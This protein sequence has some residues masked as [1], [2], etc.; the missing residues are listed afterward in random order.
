L[1]K[2][3][4]FRADGNTDIGFGHVIRCLALADMLKDHF[5]CI[6]ATRFVNKYIIEEIEK[7]CS[8]YIKL[9]EGHN[10]HFDEFLACVFK[11]DIVVL[12]NYFFT[13]DYQKQIKSIECKLICI[14]DMH[15]KHYVADIVIN[16]GPG[17][18][19]D[20]FSAE[21]YT[22]L[23]LGLDY[24]LLRKPFLNI[25]QR[26]RTGVKKCLVCI[27]G[28]DKHNITSKILNLLEENVNIDTVDVIIGSSFLFKTE[29]ENHIDYSEKE[30]NLYSGLSSNEMLDRM[31]SAD[32]G[33]FPASSISLEAISVGLPFMV[34]Y[35]VENQEELYNNLTKVYNVFGL[36]NLLN[37]DGL[38]IDNFDISHKFS[39]I[40]SSMNLKK[41]FKKL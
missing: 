22:K 4:Y 7:S 21:H 15:D 41:V 26:K 9:K 5:E 27:G 11:E 19:E 3:I 30:V 2:K 10:E 40:N 20:Q 13:T 31:Q 32:F 36:D 12:D 17:L 34:G 6:F 28:A 14:D 1:R 37:I 25:V 33:I 38:L 39:T 23:C 24:A 29:L 16:H 35:Y 18:T 8:S